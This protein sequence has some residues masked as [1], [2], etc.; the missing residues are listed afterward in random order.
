MT[1]EKYHNIFVPLTDIYC[2]AGSE[3]FSCLE[4]EENHKKNLVVLPFSFI[5]KLDEI[6][7]KNFGAMETL[8]KIKNYTNESVTINEENMYIV[9]ALGGLDIAFFKS[10]KNSEVEEICALNDFFREKY[11]QQLTIITK[12]PKEHLLL[13][14]RGLCVEDPKFLKVGEEIVEEGIIF[15]NNELLSEIY[16]NNN[17]LSLEKAIEIM[18]R[19]LYHNQ[20]IKFL[21]DKNY[22]YAMVTG[23]IVKNPSG[24]KIIGVEKSRVSFLKPDEYNKILRIR[25]HKMESIFGI[26]P[27]DMEQYIALQYGLLNPD[28][29]VVFICGGHGSGKTL[30]SY[31]SAIDLV[32]WYDKYHRVK[33]GI[34][35]TKNGFFKKIILLKS[36]DI[37]GGSRRDIGW[38]PGDLYSKIR[39]FLGS[40]IDAH[41]KSTLGS[42]MP[43]EEMFKHPKFDNGFGEPRKKEITSTKINNCAY[44]PSDCEVIELTYSGYMRGRSL[45]D[46]LL[47]IDEAPNFTPFE[48]KTIFQRLGEG[49][50]C[51]LL[52]DTSQIDNPFCSPDFNGFTHAIKYYLDKPYSILVKLTRNYRSQISQDSDD[53][54]TFNLR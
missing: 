33:R 46:T 32:L 18:E 25:E 24:S 43:F 15:G 42:I 39:P 31:V 13:K 44:L 14:A 11:N 6:K 38:L 50:K 22:I 5:E 45:E 1:T 17:Q 29:S 7:F 30:L 26:S 3:L 37:V 21:T 49:S 52:G 9:K 40:Y 4:R 20:I 12:E 27:R 34:S 16:S 53:W 35:E 2:I 28:V 47:I 36:N 51:I 19:P 10:D 8:E 41:N 48:I 54:K 23:D